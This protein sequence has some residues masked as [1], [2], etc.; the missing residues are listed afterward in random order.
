MMD[1]IQE[2]R[3]RFGLV[4]TI[5]GVLITANGVWAF[6]APQSF[7][8]TLATYPPYNRHLFHDIGAFSIGLGVAFLLAMRWRNALTVVIAA[9]AIAAVMHAISHIIDRDLGGKTSDPWLLSAIA[10]ALAIPAIR[11][12]RGAR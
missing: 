12:L 1:T 5:V 8:D 4:W 9:N 6:F 10:L 11:R 2:E 7:Y 3:T